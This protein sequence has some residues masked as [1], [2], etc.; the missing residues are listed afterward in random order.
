MWRTG[1]AVLTSA[2]PTRGPGEDG[3]PCQVLMLTGLPVFH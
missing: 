1:L 2:G 3:M